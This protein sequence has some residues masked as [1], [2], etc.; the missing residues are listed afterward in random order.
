MI[1]GGKYE[2]EALHARKVTDADGLVLI[3]MNG[4]KGHGFSCAFAN[5]ELAALLP[6]A[7]RSVAD[8]VEADKGVLPANEKSSGTREEKP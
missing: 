5:P 3:V 4:I 7:L 2:L 8:Q 6:A 1:G